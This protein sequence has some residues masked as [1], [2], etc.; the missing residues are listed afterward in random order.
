DWRPAAP[1][2]RFRGEALE[3][4]TY[5]RLF[6][7]FE[8]GVSGRV[9]LGDYVTATEGTGLVHTAPPFGGDDNQPGVRS[10]LPLMLT[11]ASEG[12]MAAGAGAFAGVWFKDADAKIVADLKER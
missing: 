11:V 7:Y 10:G 1:L 9:V 8:P 3:N 6:E 5:D 12:K 4:L 2:A